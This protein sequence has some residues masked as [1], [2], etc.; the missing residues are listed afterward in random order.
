M[1]VA[2][3]AEWPGA[4][5]ARVR[6]RTRC[7]QA[8][9]PGRYLD[10]LG[11]A[12]KTRQAEGQTAERQHKRHQ[13]QASTRVFN[14][15]LRKGECASIS[16]I[17][18]RRGYREVQSTR[19]DK[20]ECKCISSSRDRPEAMDPHPWPGTRYQ[21]K[22]SSPP[23]GSYCHEAIEAAREEARGSES[24][25]TAKAQERAV[26]INSTSKQSRCRTVWHRRLR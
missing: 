5:R 20:G 13:D 12:A 19:V 8:G 2:H 10:D 26:V 1:R 24:S 15:L 11:G 16:S 23:F 18:D 4:A 17:P 7:A 14:H 3:P 21:S 25:Q 9:D 6:R 22:S